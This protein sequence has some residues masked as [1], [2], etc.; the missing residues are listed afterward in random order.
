MLLQG[1]KGND[2]VMGLKGERGSK[3]K[4]NEVEIPVSSF[5]SGR[6]LDNF[7]LDSGVIVKS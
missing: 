5:F 7:V 6:A 2:G 3:V 1:E 4:S